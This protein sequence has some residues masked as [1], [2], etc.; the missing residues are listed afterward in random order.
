MTNKIFALLFL[1]PWVWGCQSEVDTKLLPQND[2]RLFA[3]STDLTFQSD[4]DILFIIDDSGSMQSHQQRLVDNFSL[5]TEQLIKAQYIDFRVGVISSS[6]GDSFSRGQLVDGNL[7]VTNGRNFISKNTPNLANI[8]SQH[9]LL[10]DSGSGTEI[11]FDNIMKTFSQ[12]KLSNQNKGF[13]RSNG[14]LALFFLTD[15]FDQ[16][17]ASVNA[18]ERFLLSLKAGDRGRVHVA[19]ALVLEESPVCRRDG[20]NRPSKMIELINRFDRNNVFSLCSSNFGQELA[21]VAETIVK[22]ASV[23]RLNKKIPS[24]FSIRLVYGSQEIPNDPLK[25]WTYNPDENLIYLGPDLVLEDE[26]EGL[27]VRVLLNPVDD[28]G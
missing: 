8:L 28:E 17:T 22:G 2:P 5:F 26:G 14:Q 25:G 3:S 16:G 10:G 15:T 9:L 13:Y 20:T 6:P 12:Q 7:K 4:V 21:R 18:M 19:G 24:S 27:Q 23:I 1:I 11:F